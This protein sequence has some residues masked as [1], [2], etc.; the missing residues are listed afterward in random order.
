M[1]TDNL[2]RL[3]TLLLRLHVQKVSNRNITHI[4]NGWYWE[5]AKGHPRSSSQAA[6]Q[7]LSYVFV[8]IKHA[9]Q[10]TLADN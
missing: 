10:E 8:R 3:N 6:S 9:N 7:Y 1:N 5:A 4:R 2:F